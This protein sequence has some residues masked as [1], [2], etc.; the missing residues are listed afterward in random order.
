M[1]PVEPLERLPADL[2]GRLAAHLDQRM[3]LHFPP[4]R[5]GDLERGLRSVM[6][7][8]GCT[9]LAQCAEKLLSTELAR[10]EIEALA[11]HLTVGETYFFRDPDM[12]RA[13]EATVL[14]DLIARCPGGEQH[15]RIWSAACSSGE[16]PYSVAMTLDRAFPQVAAW[17]NTILATDIN[18]T[19]LAKARHREYGQWSF[20]GTPDWVRARYFEEPR[21]GSYRL[22]ARIRAMVR[23]FYLNLAEDA[24]PSLLNNTNAMDLILCRNVMIYFNAEGARRVVRRLC[25]CLVEGGWLS[26][27]PSESFLLFDSPLKMVEL[28]GATFFRKLAGVAPVWVEPAAWS[29]GTEVAAA[30]PSEPAPLAPA[31]EPHFAQAAAVTAEDPLAVARAKANQGH[32]EE[33][34]AACRQAVGAQPLEAPVRYLLGTVCQE[35][36]LLDEAVEAM[37][38]AL[39]LDP[40]HVVAHFALGNLLLQGGRRAQAARHFRNVRELL[41]GRPDDEPLPEGEGVTAGR[42]REVAELIISGEGRNE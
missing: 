1:P 33:A 32:L 7:E 13:L 2:H 9:S 42:L 29:S 17:P 5:A 11:A 34:L 37:R 21:P 18:A 16:E 19:A 40:D 24:Y 39:Y 25:D 22:D 8:F 4:E 15:L 27:T 38:R 31:R 30:P 6:A 14:P 26:V 20:R 28:N 35:L 36:G 3:G 23:F 12:F 41:R 10:S